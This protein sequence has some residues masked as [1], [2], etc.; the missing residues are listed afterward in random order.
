MGTNLPSV[1]LGS[2]WTAVEVAAGGYHTCVRLQ[3]G[4]EKVIKCWGYNSY[5]QLGLGDTNGWGGGRGQMG[6]SLPAVQLG[7]GRSAVALALGD[8]H[9][10]ALLD[11]A[12]VKCWG[13]N[14]YSQLGMGDT[15]NRGDGSGE[16]G[17]SLSVVDLG[18]G[19]TVVQLVAGRRH[20]CALLEDG[21]LCVRAP[22]PP[23]PGWV[24]SGWLERATCVGSPIGVEV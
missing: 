5:G 19:R 8:E 11:D 2:G 15:R 14:Y 17:D 21:Q 6:D 20:N 9:S 22:P 12:S 13:W 3:N 18:P 1:D 4:A 23:P 10:C 16:M 7:T 24:A